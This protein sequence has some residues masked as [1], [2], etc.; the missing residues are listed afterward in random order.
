MA[1]P[2]LDGI[3]L[4]VV[5]APLTGEPTGIDL[6]E[7]F[8]PDSIYFRLRDARAGA[9]DLER[10]SETASGETVTPAQWREV[11]SLAVDALAARSKDLE[12]AC[13]LTEA[14]VRTDGL[15]GLAVGAEILGGLL[16]RYWDALFPMP[17]EDGIE[18]RVAPV[19]G[20]SGQG[21]DGTLLQP[22]RR[23]TLFNRPDGA[24]FAFWQY[25]ST[26]ELAAI[27]D[28][29]RR[30]QRIEAGTI[31]FEDVEKEARFAGPAHWTAR[32]HDVEE[33]LTAWSAMS[34]V[35]DRKAAVDSPSTSRVR[36]LLGAMAELCRRFSPAG[37]KDDGSGDVSTGPGPQGASAET[38]EGLP[39]VASAAPG[40]IGGREQ[41][42]RQ[43][44]DIA[45][46]FRRHEP[47]S[48]LAYTLEEAVRRGRM[49]WPELLDELIPD[50][51]SRHALLTSLGI[52]PVIGD[53]T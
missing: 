43:L 22:L 21:Y 11:R 51:T 24:P 40:G 48:P 46:W 39:A 23:L 12:V 14:L 26:L 1:A 3:D 52:K 4:D 5:L 10:Q 6:R 29:T 45:A 13:W 30:A 2:Q 8:S 31:A 35:L 50:E 19:G 28:P 27:T 37:N 34:E 53:G 49:T 15:S 38:G 17:D 16:E 18:T 41:A 47:H 44:G 9:R 7:D 25:E 36:D 42:L 20:L 33:A 32:L